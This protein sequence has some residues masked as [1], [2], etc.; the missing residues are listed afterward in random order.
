MSQKINQPGKFFG[1]LNAFP[2]LRLF[3]LLLVAATAI[4]IFILSCEV[5]VRVLKVNI[6][7]KSAFIIKIPSKWKTLKDADFRR[8]KHG[9][10]HPYLGYVPGNYRD[11]R[12]DALSE[13]V[14][15][16][17]G[18]CN[19][20][21][22]GGSAAYYYG[23]YELGWSHSSGKVVESEKG[24]EGKLLKHITKKYKDSSCKTFTVLNFAVGGGFAPMQMHSFV[25]NID[26]ID[27]AIVIDGYNEVHIAILDPEYYPIDYPA[28]YYYMDYLYL[29]EKLKEVSSLNFQ[30]YTKAYEL[31]DNYSESSLAENSHLIKLFLHRILLKLGEKLMGL[32]EEM[33]KMKLSHLGKTF[34][35]L[36]VSAEP[37][38]KI[39]QDIWKKSV[40][41]IHQTAKTYSIPVVHILQPLPFPETKDLTPSEAKYMED[42][43]QVIHRRHYKYYS[44][45]ISELA[46]EGV[47][48]HN[49]K[50]IFSNFKGTAYKDPVHLTND[51]NAI[52]SQYVVNAIETSFPRILPRSQK[53]KIDY[54]PTL[55]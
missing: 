17:K 27:M 29:D 22:F 4:V 32:Q 18:H 48:V 31:I 52:F 11:R 40:R 50:M 2:V 54:S 35:G 10:L 28:W 21:I 20:G 53:L 43:S 44:Q 42:P 49:S 41:I 7:P 24:K 15:L 5:A 47:I 8:T 14:I 33:T 46:E 16:K 26:L 13:P 23:A 19:I 38:E 12:N 25:R 9:S 1:P 6:P 39:R 34:P 37:Y 55:K 3:F 45:L 36:T 51:G 30:F